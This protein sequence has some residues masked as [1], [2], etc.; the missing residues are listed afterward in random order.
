MNGHEGGMKPH[1]SDGRRVMRRNYALIVFVLCVLVVAALAGCS[2]GGGT[3]SG[4]P[5]SQGVIVSLNN[6]AFEPSQIQIAKGETVTFRNDD[7]VTHDVV[8]DGWDSGTLEPG[9]SF[10]H[11]FATAGT[12]AIHCSIH[13]SMTATVIVK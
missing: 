8:G 7:S 11:T 1:A 3:K 6:L 9:K 4:T 12:F 10:P 13:P 2:S 5:S